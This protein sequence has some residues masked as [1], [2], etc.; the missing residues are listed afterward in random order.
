M[1]FLIE[2]LNVLMLIS[3]P[4]VL[5]LLLDPLFYK[6][7][8]TEAWSGM[9]YIVCSYGKV[10]LGRYLRNAGGMQWIFGCQEYDLATTTGVKN[11]F[12][13]HWSDCASSKCSSG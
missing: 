13:L 3:S 1:K 5:S 12:H 7:K 8:D 11:I 4:A 9:I 2:C 6:V 10:R